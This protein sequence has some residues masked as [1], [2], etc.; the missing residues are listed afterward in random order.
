[1]STVTK[2][3][4]GQLRTVTRVPNINTIDE[5]C[6]PGYAHRMPRT[7]RIVIPGLPPHVTPVG[8][9]RAYREGLEKFGI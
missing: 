9:P 2:N 3:G 8:R 6:Y 7:T 4:P 1:M 5:A